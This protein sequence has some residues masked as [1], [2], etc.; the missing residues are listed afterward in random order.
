[1]Q[2]QPASGPASS[3]GKRAVSVSRKAAVRPPVHPPAY[4]GMNGVKCAIQAIATQRMNMRSTMDGR[5]AAQ[6]NEMRVLR[7]LHRFGWLR[8]RDLATLCWRRWSPQPAGQIALAPIKPTSSG[9][10]MA[11]RTLSRLRDAALVVTGHGPDG[12]VIYALS[13]GGARRLNAK[14]IVASTGKD[15]VRGFSSTHYRHRCI[16]NEVA[17]AAIIQGYRVST[18]REIAQGL[19][20]G[21][22]AG[23]AGKRPDVLARGDGGVYWVEVERSRKNAKEYQALLVWLVK[24]LRDCG[25]TG[26]SQLLTPGQVWAGI[27]FICSPTFERKLRQDLKNS[28]WSKQKVDSVCFFETLLY[29][30]EGISFS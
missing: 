6:E 10:R 17:I 3:R 26:D 18:E 11:Q 25:G 5:L 16:A 24:V 19:W 15:R 27:I 2:P 4:G 22:S 9:L 28:G 30:L 12:S 8:T 29:S 23:I 1:M 7:A 14:G 20:Q 13:A 21:G